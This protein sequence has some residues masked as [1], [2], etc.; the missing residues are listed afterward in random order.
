MN[1]GSKIAALADTVQSR[2]KLLG[3]TQ[4]ELA[5]LAEVSPRFV[6]DLESGKD[7]L[8]MNRVIRVCN[9]LGLR[10]EWKLATGE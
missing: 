7:T 9:V 8:S 5:D 1:P 2:R 3:L 6:F 10:L 4:A